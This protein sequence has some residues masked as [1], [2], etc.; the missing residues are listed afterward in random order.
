MMSQTSQHHV[1]IIDHWEHMIGELVALVLQRQ[2][3]DCTQVIVG[4]DKG[5]QA[6]QEDLPDVVFI[7]LWA[8]DP[9]ALD[10]CQQIRASSRTKHLPV[11]VWGAKLPS[12]ICPQLRD[13]GATGYL[14]QPCTPDEIL[15]ARDVALEGGI[16][17]SPDSAYR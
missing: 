5:L 14:Y 17:F 9:S 2:R 11:I 1:L 16:Y 13:V 8:H 6:I 15:A 10:F 7:Y 3:S 12:E 4:G